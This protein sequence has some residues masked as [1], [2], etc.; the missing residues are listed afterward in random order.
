[1][2][3]TE[4]SQEADK[5]SSAQ[6]ATESWINTTRWL[7]GW[8]AFVVLYVVFV[9]CYLAASGTR[10]RHGTPYN[11]FAYL[12]DS[13]LN[14]RLDLVRSPPNEND[15]AKV[16]VLTLRDGRTVKGML[17][18]RGDPDRFYPLKGSVE[19]IM[20][21]QIVSRSYI[22]YVSFPPFPAV[23]MLPLVAIAGVAANDVIFTALWAAINPALL[24]LLLRR[25][26]QRGHSERGVSEDL[27]LTVAFGVGSV[28]FYS[29]VFG[30]VWYTAHIVA[31]TLVIGYVWASLDVQHPFL[32]GLFLGLGFA[33]RTPLGFAFVL[34]V[35]EAVRVHGGWRQLWAQKRIPASLIVVCI[36]A[37]VPAL[38]IVA[39]L[40]LHNHLRFER[41]TEFGHKYLN[42][43]WQERILRWG[44]FNY[45]FMSRNLATA[46]VLLP[47]I[48][49]KAPYVQVSQHGMSVLITSP[50]LILLLW[51]R[52]R[53]PLALGLGL[54]VLAT[55]LPS[56]LYQNSGFVQFGY[57][58]S[59]DYMVLLVVLLAL[60]NRRLGPLFK[61]MVV[62][63]IGVNLFGALTFDRA[64]Q[65]TYT[66]T[67]FPHGSN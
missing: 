12:A 5:A 24:F 58:F 18:G 31:T 61:V 39:A 17:G 9:A 45:H 23:L 56:L 35:F 22:R 52:R 36:K 30:Q 19:T 3:A 8:R 53:S 6:P 14:G 49:A 33:T 15:W 50:F 62:V 1:M 55:A 32:A 2:K 13:W 29:S 47:R 48:L 57:R 7:R 34:F 59:L 67:F 42:I 64:Q 60:G 28:Y 4:A 38:L 51:P 16:D 65:F 41:L 10:L 54:T 11:H 25:L 37:A 26:R 63:A 66:D 44:L 43:T 21:D 46:L 40:L 20:P 27:W